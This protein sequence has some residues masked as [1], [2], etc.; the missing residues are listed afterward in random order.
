MLMG[1][2]MKCRKCKEEYM[3]E[4]HS[5]NPFKVFHAGWHNLAIFT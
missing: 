2:R 5:Y 4:C 1:F 3:A